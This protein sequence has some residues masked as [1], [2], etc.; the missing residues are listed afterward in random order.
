M[1][2]ERNKKNL[3]IGTVICLFCIF[4]LS[5]NQAL[6]ANKFW[7]GSSGGSAN[8][9]ANWSLTSG[10]SGG[11]KV[12]NVYDSVNFDTHS[13]NATFNT[14]GMTLGDLLMTNGSGIVTINDGVILNVGSPTNLAPQVT[15]GK[16]GEQIATTT[17]DAGNQ[18][19][20]GAFTLLAAGASVDVSSIRIKQTGSF[21]TAN[22]TNVRLY[23]KEAVDGQCAAVKPD[24]A[25]IFGTAG[26]FDS[27]NFATTTVNPPLTLSPDVPVCLYIVYSLN[28]TP[29]V[30]TMGRS[31]DFEITNPATDVAVSAGTVVP[32]TSVNISGVTMIKVSNG[33]IPPS[34][35]PDTNP[36]CSDNK[37]TSMISLHMSDP[38]N[39]PTVYYLENC[40]VWKK[41]GT[42]D[43][44]RLT[45]PNLQVHSLIFTNM[46]GASGGTSVRMEINMSNM[47]PGKEGTFMNVSR[48]YK[49]TAT[50]RAWSGTE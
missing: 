5:D 8:S 28:G 49:T 10:G 4:C 23:S 17:A 39:D 6:A 43:P 48:T 50:V 30:G 32:G 25:V 33:S 41:A 13:L 31:I 36:S 14:T 38:G 37:I 24:G 40:A 42:G 29:G 3:I 16:S 46:S 2:R 19:L 15:V 9:T 22:F 27:G 20:G 7:V 18:D 21:P 26:N 47:D 11:A 44:V 35:H 34:P 12:P 1:N 45:N